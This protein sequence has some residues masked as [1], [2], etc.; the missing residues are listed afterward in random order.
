[1][2]LFQGFHGVV[3]IKQQE[4]LKAYI[5]SIAMAS[6]WC[7]KEKANVK[8]ER[9]Y[10]KWWEGK[11]RGEKGRKGEEEGWEI[12]REGAAVCEYVQ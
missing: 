12:E 10:C 8:R 1:M 3:S 2:L 4:K 9:I 6:D 7:L 5:L 11:G